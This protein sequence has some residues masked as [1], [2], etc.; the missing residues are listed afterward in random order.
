MFVCEQAISFLDER[1]NKTFILKLCDF[2][3]CINNLFKMEKEKEKTKEKEEI[4]F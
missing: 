2:F 3:F 4:V 1:D